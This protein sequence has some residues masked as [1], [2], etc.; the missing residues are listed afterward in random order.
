MSALLGPAA[1]GGCGRPEPV[2]VEPSVL[3]AR[4][5]EVRSDKIHRSNPLRWCYFCANWHRSTDF[6][7]AQLKTPMSARYCQR[8]TSAKQRAAAD[9]F[10]STQPSIERI[11][12]VAKLLDISLAMPHDARLSKRKLQPQRSS[13]SQESAAAAATSQT[14]DTAG[15]DAGEG[16]RGCDR[17]AEPEPLAPEPVIENRVTL[18]T[19][20][21]P[22]VEEELELMRAD[23]SVVEARS[24]T[25]V[26]APMTY[27][28]FTDKFQTVN[29]SARLRFFVGLPHDHID[30]QGVRVQGLDVNGPSAADD[31]RRIELLTRAMQLMTRHI[32]EER[33]RDS[34]ATFPHFSR[35][36]NRIKAPSPPSLTPLCSSCCSSCCSY[37]SR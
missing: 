17:T 37:S 16:I 36:F 20:L 26:T 25:M 8:F 12:E 32:E 9:V 35:T 15:E 31:T 4:E 13:R 28:E 2:Q 33:A 5:V 22:L 3:T 19:L 23:T 11:T 24:D 30:S 1:A 27:L 29:P 7:D 34:Y 10:P 14:E 21:D 18:S 6:S